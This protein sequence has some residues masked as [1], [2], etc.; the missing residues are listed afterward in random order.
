LQLLIIHQI[1]MSDEQSSTRRSARP[2]NQTSILV[3]SDEQESLDRLACRAD[4]ID[5][6]CLARVP[7]LG[8]RRDIAVNSSLR[9]NAMDIYF[10]TLHH[11]AARKKAEREAHE[12]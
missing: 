9:E 10:L 7:W 12:L 4:R 1:V 11:R 2:R 5:D 6:G 8:N 3:D